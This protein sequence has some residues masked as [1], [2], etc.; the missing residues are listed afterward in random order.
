M[1]ERLQGRRL[2]ARLELAHERGRRRSHDGKQ[3]LNRLQD[4]GHAA[5]RQR[6]GA[7]PHDLPVR[8]MGIAPD[9]LDRIGRGVRGVER[10]VESVERLLEAAMSDCHDV[11]CR[12]RTGRN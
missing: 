5:E 10:R 11:E 12:T 3:P 2:T 4:A 8:R 9:D 7:E 6:C 1:N